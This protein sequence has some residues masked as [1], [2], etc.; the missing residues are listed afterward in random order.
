MAR[1]PKS[2]QTNA[3]MYKSGNQSASD[4]FEFIM[5]TQSV[6][7]AGDIIVQKGWR[8][9]EFKKNPIALFGHQHTS[10]IGTWKNV[11]VEG[12]RLIGRLQMARRGTSRMVDEVRALLEQRV[13]RS[14][15]VGFSALEYEPL[16]KE[17]PYS[18]YKFTKTSLHECSV[19]SVPANAEA[20]A[21]AK[22]LGISRKTENLIFSKSNRR[23]PVKTRT[24]N[25]PKIRH[26]SDDKLER[27]LKQ[28][29]AKRYP[30]DER[31][32]IMNTFKAHPDILRAFLR[33]E[34]VL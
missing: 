28:L 14:V 16:D 8:L 1:Q 9:R 30:M 6:D 23:V 24:T 31:I 34:N 13:L 27:A 32:A 25:R 3:T 10:P 19:V 20:L 17:S 21:I 12:K 2:I 11:R 26:R 15:S 4:P 5:S 18:G 22:S 29:R 7:R 33:G